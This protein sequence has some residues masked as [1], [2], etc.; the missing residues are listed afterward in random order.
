M[1]VGQI[2]WVGKHKNSLPRWL[3]TSEFVGSL[4]PP[5]TLKK[6]L[7]LE[8]NYAGNPRLNR[9]DFAVKQAAK[10][11]IK[12]SLQIVAS[13]LLNQSIHQRAGET[14]FENGMRALEEIK[15]RRDVPIFIGAAERKA[16][17]KKRV[18]ANASD[19]L[20]SE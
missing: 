15:K 3:N 4:P 9:D 10:K 8:T 13:E 2:F 16:I 5:D 11:I 7:A 19:K 14:E 1:G 12:G 18:R 20:P 17:R 6:V